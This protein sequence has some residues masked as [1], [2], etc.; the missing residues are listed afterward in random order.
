VARSDVTGARRL[1]ICPVHI[2]AGNRA[3]RSIDG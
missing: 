2:A 1:Q 3:F